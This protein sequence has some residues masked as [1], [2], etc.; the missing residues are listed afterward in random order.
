MRPGDVSM[1]LRTGGDAPDLARR[2]PSA[3]ARRLDPAP[4]ALTPLKRRQ[5][6]SIEQAGS[7]RL[8]EGLSPKGHW[9][10]TKRHH[11]PTAVHHK[12]V[13]PGRAA[14]RVAYLSPIG[15]FGDD[16]HG[17]AP[18]TIDPQRRVIRSRPLAA[19]DFVSFEAEPSGHAIAR[20][21]MPQCRRAVLAL[22][23]VFTTGAQT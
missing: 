7:R 21:G 10:G 18:C 8:G 17:K 3:D 11:C 20:S 2:R 4:I 12:A 13:Y 16:L 15:G 6:A 5:G 19:K 1:T 9:R 22:L 14:V 23:G